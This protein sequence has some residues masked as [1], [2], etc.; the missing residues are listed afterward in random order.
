MARVGFFGGSFDPIHNGH[1]NLALQIFEAHQL[2]QIY[3]CPTSQSPH[4]RL[5]PPVASKEDRR[6]MVVAAIAPL[7]QFTFLDVEIQKS[8]PVYTIDSIRLLLKTDKDKKKHYFLILGEDALERFHEW[9]EVEELV[10]IAPPLIG[11]RE[12]GDKGAFPKTVPKS[13]AAAVKKGM[14]KTSLMEIS[15]REI[16]Q[17]M[18]SSL[19]CGHLLPAKVWDHINQ[20]QLYRPE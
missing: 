6:A 15:S 13:V 3:F 5:N 16:R 10:A 14:T 17:R 11:T 9:K 19:Y 2:D 18:A 20:N 8:G 1:L 12:A 4:K 7:P